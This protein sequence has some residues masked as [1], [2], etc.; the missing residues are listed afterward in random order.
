MFCTLRSRLADL[1]RRR[2]SDEQPDNVRVRLPPPRPPQG[3]AQALEQDAQTAPTATSDRA[4]GP[5]RTGP[6][7]VDL[8][9]LGPDERQVRRHMVDAI[10]RYGWEKD[11]TA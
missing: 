8:S 11:R 7:R 4:D 2:Q 9:Q 3:A 6:E 5:V 1:I 10:A